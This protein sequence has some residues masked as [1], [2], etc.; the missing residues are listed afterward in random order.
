MTVSDGEFI[1]E[2]IN[3]TDYSIRRVDGVR[4][5]DE[6]ILPDEYEG[7]PVTAI[8]SSHEVNGGAF[9]NTGIKSIT[10]PEGYTII[11]AYAFY[12]CSNLESITIPASIKLIGSYA[13]AGCINLKSII[14]EDGSQLFS[15]GNNAFSNCINLR[16][17]ELPDGIISIGDYAFYDCNRLATVLIPENIT[18]IGDKA[19]YYCRM[20]T[21]VGVL[22]TTLPV[23]GKEVFWVTHPYLKIYV[24]EEL[25]EEYKLAEEWLNHG[26]K[27]YPIELMDVDG[28]YIIDGVLLQYLGSDTDIEIPSTVTKIGS[29]AFANKP[30]TSVIIPNSVT[31]IENSAFEGCL[32]LLSI[33]IAETVERIGAYAFYNCINLGS[34]GF[35]IN[36]QLIDIGNYAFSNCKVLSTIEIPDGVTRIGDGA[37]YDC[38]TLAE[39]EI[40][41]SVTYIGD[42]AFYYCHLLTAVILEAEIPS[43]IGRDVFWG[44]HKDFL[45][46]VP[47]GLLSDYINAVGW[48]YYADRIVEVVEVE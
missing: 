36:S 19:F 24:L 14:F 20:L 25:I 27:I 4:L 1:Y 10:I 12:G 22:A 41:E 35:V 33:E 26:G 39:I 40:P 28:F 15:I 29:Y 47:D 18:N 42:K 13:F 48:D 30:I 46:Y 9:A 8:F 11:G 45:I 32:E 38:R 5:Q 21:T 3:D 44:N 2:L 34:A 31:S 43:T 23:L 6:V 7:I 17:I 37:F 16:S